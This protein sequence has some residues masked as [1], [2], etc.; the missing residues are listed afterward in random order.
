[1]PPVTVYLDKQAAEKMKRAA[2][3]EGKS[4]SKWLAERVDESINEGWS[5]EALAACG[6]FKDFPLAE[7][8][9]ARHGTDI[10]RERL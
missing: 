7:E 6:A 8:I 9:R 2:K 4:V 3:A 10:P 5:E 1:M